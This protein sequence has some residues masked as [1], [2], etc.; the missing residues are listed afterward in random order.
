V[1]INGQRAIL[2][3]EL[4]FAGSIFMATGAEDDIKILR[5]ELANAF[6]GERRLSRRIET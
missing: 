6:R 2:Q 4:D 1:N 5:S 3:P